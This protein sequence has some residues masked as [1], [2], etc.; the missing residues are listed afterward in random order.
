ML[1]EV[2]R[3]FEWFKISDYIDE[4]AKNMVNEDLVILPLQ[5]SDLFNMLFC[6]KVRPVMAW[7]SSLMFQLEQTICWLLDRV[8]LDA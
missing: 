7:R 5:S 8:F 6:M 4:E 1:S 3:A 2:I